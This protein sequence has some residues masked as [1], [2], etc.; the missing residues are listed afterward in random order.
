MDKTYLSSDLSL[1]AYLSM[2]GLEIVRASRL[3][4]GKFEFELNDPDGRAESLALEYVNSDFS[5]FDNQ[6]R[7]LKKILYTK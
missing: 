6:I 1:A 3:P 2:R 7:L 5:K 4:G